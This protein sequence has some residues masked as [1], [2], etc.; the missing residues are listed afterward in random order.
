MRRL[1]NFLAY[2]PVLIISPILIF[3]AMGALAL[4]DL[5]WAIAGKRALSPNKMPDRNSA[6]VVIPNWNGR[7]LLE[8]YLPSVVEAMSGHPN[9]EVIVVDNASTDG[10]TQLLRERFPTVRVLPLPKNRGFGGGSNA[11]FR[12][13]KNDIVV[14][15]NSDMRVEADFLQPLLDGFNDESVFAVSCQIF[16]SD[17]D[18]VREET[19]LTQVW[20]QGGRLRARHRIDTAINDAYPCFYAGGGSS[21]FDRHKFLELGG[22]DSLLHPFYLEDTDLGFMAWKRGWKVLYQP[23]S[24]VYHEHRGT[25]GKKFSPFYINWILKK[26]FVLFCWKNIHD[27]RCCSSISRR[28]GRTRQSALP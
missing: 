9:N 6:S 3:T 2:L 4:L 27:W 16:F 5:I 21:A 26:N 17:P 19:G 8:K 11:G 20:W 25:I 1:F 7:D 14:L 10:S 28:P 23:R 24:V 15:L 22:F 18:K 13:A 12:A